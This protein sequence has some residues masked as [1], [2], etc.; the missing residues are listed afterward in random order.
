METTKVIIEYVIAGILMIFALV[1]LFMS[2]FSVTFD[3]IGKFIISIPS[4]D[5]TSDIIS[6]ANGLISSICFLAVAYSLGVISEYMGMISLEWMIEREKKSRFPKFIDQNLKDL[7]KSPLLKGFE[8]K[9]KKE[10][11]SHALQLYGQMRF[12]VM[13]L[14][15]TL[16]AE[17]ENQLNRVR[18]TRVMLLVEVIFIISLSIQLFSSSI[19]SNVATVMFVTMIT[20]SII[21]FQSI[22]KRFERYCRSI[23]RSYKEIVFCSEVVKENDHSILFQ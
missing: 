4:A 16:Y 3:T 19:N 9:T 14:S 1:L 8:N 18:L 11:E 13:E 22:K 17:I 23:E 7:D 6:S 10:I 2:I 5:K 12:H 21:T 20:L 15:E